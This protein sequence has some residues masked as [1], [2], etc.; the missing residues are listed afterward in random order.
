MGNEV[1]ELLA[2]QTRLERE[3]DQFQAMFEVTRTLAKPSELRELFV[4]VSTALRKF[5]RQDYTGL[6]IFED[7]SN[8]LRLYAMD[9]PEGKSLIREDLVMPRAG[10]LCGAALNSGKPVLMTS[11]PEGEMDFEVSRLLHVW[12]RP[13]VKGRFREGWQLSGIYT[14]QTG[15]P[16]D[17]GLAFDN[18]N[19]GNSGSLD[20]PN[21]VGNPNANAPHTVLDWFNTAAFAAL[22][23]YTFGI[24]AK[25]LSPDQ[26]FR[27]SICFSVR[28]LPPNRAP[29]DPVPGRGLQ[30]CESPQFRPAKCGLWKSVVW[31]NRLRGRRSRNTIGAEVSFLM[32]QLKER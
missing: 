10:S 7:H 16:V 28:Y 8:H 15:T 26:A 23:Q 25:T 9:F 29:S 17:V 20:R 1:E 27:T 14:I 4:Q 30:C 19:T 11:L 12:A 13:F 2:T 24:A 32:M 31:A 3:R 22:V 21:C 6:A 18:S 5:V